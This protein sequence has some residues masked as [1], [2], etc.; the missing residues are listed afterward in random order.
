MCALTLIR[1]AALAVFSAGLFFAPPAAAQTPVLL[2][3]VLAVDCSSSVSDQEFDLQ[4][5]GLAKAFEDPLVL[6]ALEQVGP[7]GVAVSLLQWSGTEDQVRAIEWRLI[8]D[9]A[10][11]QAFAQAIDA[12]PRF[13]TGGATAIG[14]AL[15]NATNWIGSNAFEG[16]RRVI[17]LSGD[18]RANQG[19]A[20]GFARARALARGITI[21]GL[22]IL[23]EEPRLA[24]YFAA[25]V[26][27][28]PSYFLLSADDYDDFARAIRKKLFFEIT[29]PP[30]VFAPGEAPEKFAVEPEKPAPAAQKSESAG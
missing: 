3:L 16:E 26:V 23:N 24:Q 25:G 13:V 17:D 1:R 6:T 5:R 15:D 12:T 28:G 7:Q 9:A 27:G 22:A 20:P 4:M 14:N 11:A 10:S 18:G 2:E 21:N 19:E 30:I 29:G 8:N